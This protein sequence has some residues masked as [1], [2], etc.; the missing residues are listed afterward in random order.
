M[1]EQE[2]TN[3]GL[4]EVPE[5]LKPKTSLSAELRDNLSDAAVGGG[6]FG[7][8]VVEIDPKYVGPQGLRQAAGVGSI[9]TLGAGIY[10]IPGT[11]DRDQIVPTSTSEVRR[12]DVDTPRFDSTGKP[13]FPDEM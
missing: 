7:R 4:I 12:R 9:E 6:R 5:H 1:T 3:D 11:Q 2:Q 10:T 13:E 8:G